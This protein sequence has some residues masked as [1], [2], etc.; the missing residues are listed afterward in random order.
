VYYRGMDKKKVTTLRLTQAVHDKL[1]RLAF[2]A[3]MAIGDYIALL[4][5]GKGVK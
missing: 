4:I 1:R 3:G 5:A 2:D